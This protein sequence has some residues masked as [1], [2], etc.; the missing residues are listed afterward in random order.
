MTPTAPRPKKTLQRPSRARLAKALVLQ[1]LPW[2]LQGAQPAAANPAA[3][4]APPASERAVERAAFQDAKFGMFI[5]WGVYST[6]GSGE[7]VMNDRPILIEDYDKL[8]AFFNPVDYKPAEWVALVKEAGMKYITITTRHH[9]GFAMYDSK[10][11]DWNIVK[12]TPYGKDVLKPL[13]AECR[14]QG[15]KLF[16]YYSH[17]DWHR[18]D[19]YPRGW[20]GKH[21]ERPESGD[22]YHYVDFMDAQLTELLTNYGEIGGIWFDGWWD[23]PDAD[24][25]LDRTYALIHKLQ[26]KCLIGNNHHVAPFPGE[27]FQMWE[28]DLPGKNDSGFNK[29]TEV[30]KLPLET[31]DTMNGSW[32]FNITDRAYKSPRQLI[33]YLARAAGNNANFLLNVGPMPNGKIQ[34]EFVERL[35]EVGKWMKVNGESIHGT[36]GGPSA[37]EA[38]GSTTYSVER[39]FVHLLEPEKVGAVADADAATSTTS[40][41]KTPRIPAV[42]ELDV[43]LYENWKTSGGALPKVVSAALLRDGKAVKFTATRDGVHLSIPK[44][45]LDE[46]DTVIV[47]GFEK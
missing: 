38:W 20:T 43:N 35:K 3:V 41:K 7:W 25:R 33:H 44:G 6:L 27:D 40:S 29:G 18:E 24:W 28:R 47:L 26:P 39:V 5:H 11:S 36:R 4:G 13:A 2:V 22:W 37:P 46:Y 19:Y 34:P 9:D 31:C 8:P 23:K 10:V 45:R 1:G 14:K 21:Q 16:F 32:G 17:L 12:R 30:G 15:I 42:V